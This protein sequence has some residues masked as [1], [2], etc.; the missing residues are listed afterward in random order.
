M[1]NTPPSVPL[2]IRSATLTDAEV[3][4]QIHTEAILGLCQE[5]YSPAQIA[6]WLAGRTPSGYLAGINTGHMFLAH[7]AGHAVGFGH[8]EP[9]IILGMFVA[10][11]AAGQGVGQQLLT[12]A[13]RIASQGVHKI[14]LTAT[15]NA[16]PFYEKAGFYPARPVAIHMGN[17]QLPFVAM[18][19]PLE[20]LAEA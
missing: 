12:Y 9:G 7:M 3:M 16:Q 18:I 1:N 6:A 17:E 10:A 4:H 14:K 19:L 15:L 11:G 13:L 20:N 2:R 5:H 8:A